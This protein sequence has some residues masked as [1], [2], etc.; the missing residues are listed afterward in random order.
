[1][2]FTDGGPCIPP[3]SLIYSLEFWNYLFPGGFFFL[4]T[5][6]LTKRIT[7]ASLCLSLS[8]SR[9]RVLFLSDIAF[10]YLLAIIVNCY[11]Y[12]YIIYIYKHIYIYTYIL[13]T[14]THT[15]THTSGI[16]CTTEFICDLSGV[17]ISLVE[18]SLCEEHVK[19][20]PMTRS[21]ILDYCYNG[22]HLS[23]RNFFF[24]IFPFLLVLF[25]F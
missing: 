7:F 12:I 24:F 21:I 11:I 16:E 6:R 13:Y 3:P 9:P 19:S 8:F 1:M 14:K 22:R 20:E 5:P 23:V 10:C 17:S 2:R 25:R 15:R 18:R 4:F